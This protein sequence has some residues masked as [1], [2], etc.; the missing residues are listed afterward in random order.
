MTPKFVGTLI[1]IMVAACFIAGALVFPHLPMVVTSHWDAAGQ[2]NGS[3]GRVWAT[4]LLPALMLLLTALWYY[5]P[6]LDPMDPGYKSFRPAYD[7]LWFLIIAFLAYVYAVVLGASVGLHLN[8]ARAIEPAVGALILA[9][10]M[11]M[12]RIKRNWFMG[13]RTPW[14]LSS[15]VV[16]TKTH[17]HAGK[18][19]VIAG[20]LTIV[21]GATNSPWGIGLGVG[22]IAAAILASVVYS[23]I[24]FKRQ[25]H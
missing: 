1:L 11:L 3:M 23:Y 4:F 16:W 22:A 18:L 17:E 13:I 10:G 19:F 5:V 6:R 15:E 12:P 8:V 9:L 20:V 14:T 25:Q 21:G 24:E 2:P 7:F